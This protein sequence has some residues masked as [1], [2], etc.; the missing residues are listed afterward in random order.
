MTIEFDPEKNHANRNKHGI[1]LAEAAS[2]LDDPMVLTIE[3]GV[4]LDERRH[5]SLGSDLVGRV[6]VVWTERGANIRLISARK[7][8]RGEAKHYRGKP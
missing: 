8:S 5:V 1:D 3:N 7:A 2:V 6:L 4:S